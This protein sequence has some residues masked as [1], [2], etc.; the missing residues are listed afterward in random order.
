MAAALDQYRVD[1]VLPILGLL[2]TDR[3]FAKVLDEL[4]RSFTEHRGRPA[5]CLFARMRSAPS[6]L[7]PITTQRVESL[8]E[9]LRAAFAA[10]YERAA[11]RGEVNP[12]I[13]RDLAASFLD[14]QLTN[15]LI[16]VTL[17]ES[18]DV[19]RAQAALLHAGLVDLGQS[20]HAPP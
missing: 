10:W 6:R 12:A 11:S 13:P 5:G 17:G 1:M 18:A 9:E 3:P 16:Q 2:A 14:A 20:F 7:G 4:V 8:R 19:I 15:V